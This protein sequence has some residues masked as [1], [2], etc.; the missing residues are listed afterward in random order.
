MALLAAL[1]A[2]ATMV[3][4]ASAKSTDPITQLKQQYH[5]GNTPIVV[6]SNLTDE[7]AFG[8]N[9]VPPEGQQSHA[10]MKP[11]LRVVRVLYW[12]FDDKVHAGQIVV[13]RDLVQDTCLLFLGMFA[14][15]FPIHSVVPESQFGY[16]DDASMAAN[17]SSNYRPEPGSEHRKGSAFDFN[18]MQ[19]PEDVTIKA[20]GVRTI[21]PAGAVRDESAKGTITKSGWVRQMW[22]AFHYEWGGGWGD[23]AATPPTD[24]CSQCTNTIFDYQHFQ[25]D[26]TRYDGLFVPEG[27]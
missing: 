25:L 24:Y 2:M 6:D 15:H 9:V 13:H 10:L 26:Y 16:N 14:G 11:Y 23:P 12:G 21:R 1:A 18:P 5:V 27:V 20:T 7:E 17:N 19:N 22:T 3:S 8:D 4:P